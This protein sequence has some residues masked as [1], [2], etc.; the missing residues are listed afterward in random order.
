MELKLYPRSVNVELKRPKKITEPNQS[1]TVRQIIDQFSRGEVM[2]KYYDPTDEIDDSRYSEEE[3]EHTI[4]FED[5]FEA[6]E[7]LESNQYHQEN[8]KSNQ[9]EHEV[10]Q[11]VSEG[12]GQTPSGE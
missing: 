7:H 11:E 1:F 8:E 6:R 9:Q 10:V 12:S 4:E 3:L 2:A 5:E